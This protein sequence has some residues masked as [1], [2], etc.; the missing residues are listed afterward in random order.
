MKKF[1]DYIQILLQIILKSNQ[2]LPKTTSKTLFRI[3]QTP[4]YDLLSNLQRAGIK[5][6]M[7]ESGG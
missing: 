1:L 7:Q 4:I 2:L 5:A 3:S 6:A